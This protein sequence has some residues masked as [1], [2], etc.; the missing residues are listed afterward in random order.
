MC[1]ELR[2]FR[3]RVEPKE[4]AREETV[5]RDTQRPRA[6]VPPTRPVPEPA[7]S[8]K[9]KVERVFEDIN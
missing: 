8:R 2:L 1:Y 4:R 3:K 7:V 6:D 9:D 5:A